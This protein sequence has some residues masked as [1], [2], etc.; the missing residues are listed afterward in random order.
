MATEVLKGP[1]PA[2]PVTS[3]WDVGDFA[4]DEKGAWYVEGYC[5]TFHED[6]GGDIVDPEAA[7]YAVNQ[8]VGL[9]LLFNH[10]IDQPIGKI[11]AARVDDHGIWMKA[12]V[13]KT[14]PTRWEQIKDGTLTKFSIRLLELQKAPVTQE[15]RQ[16]MVITKMIITEVSLTSLPMNREA[17][18]A[19]AYEAKSLY[20]GGDDMNFKEALSVFTQAADELLEQVKS[21]QVQLDA[22]EGGEA[23]SAQ[24]S[25]TPP[26]D[27]KKE[28]ESDGKPDDKTK[29][30]GSTDLTEVKELLGTLTQSVAAIAKALAGLPGETKTLV[31]T[32]A[33]DLEKRITDLEGKVDETAKTAKDAV[34]EVEGSVKTLEERM[35]EP[36]SQGLEEDDEGDKS[37][38]KS[39]N[40]KPA[41]RD[42]FGSC[43]PGSWSA[44]SKKMQEEISS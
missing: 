21:G 33:T 11:V 5:S 36:Q 18:A 26:E 17:V 37:K 12:M 2:V 13:S 41:L 29:S 25:Q 22:E 34:T 9:T 4:E 38:K 43:F 44:V 31:E 24:D 32:V 30:E 16:V 15:G 27:K 28:G 14:A 8:L 3:Y 35:P 10:D 7:E 20:M 40:Q 42:E 23:A 19:M 1:K 6:L 39:Q